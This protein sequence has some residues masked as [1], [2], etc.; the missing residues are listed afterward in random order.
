MRELSN[1]GV[2]IYQFPTDDETVSEVNVSMNVRACLLLPCNFLLIS[3][4]LAG[5]DLLVKKK[6][7]IKPIKRKKKNLTIEDPNDREKWRR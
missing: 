5:A 3:N 6:I 7:C 1:N 2:R 4:C